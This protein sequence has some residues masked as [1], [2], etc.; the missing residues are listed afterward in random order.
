MII[1]PPFLPSTTGHEMD[2]AD[3]GD[4]VVPAH[5]V[6]EV[7]MQECAPGNGAYP[8][9]FNLGWHGGAHLIAP[10]DSH[11][12]CEPVR[13]IADGTVVYVRETDT[14][15]SV[16]LSYR[17]VRTDDGCVVLKHVTE[18]GFGDHA[19]VAFFS[20]YMHLQSV[21]G[22]LAVGKKVYRKD[23]VGV[24][25]QIYGQQG[26]IH[27]EV[28]CDQRNLEKLVGRTCGQLTAAMGR[29][30]AVY[31]DVW[32]KVP[33]HTLTFANRP[34]PY[35]LDDSGPPPC[36]AIHPQ[37][38]SQTPC[39]L[40]ICMHYEGGQCT[41]TTFEKKDDRYV[42]IGSQPCINDYEYDLYKEA[43]K[44]SA[45]YLALNQAAGCAYA[46][47]PAPST[48]YEFLRFGRVL[49]PDALAANARFGHW[50]QVFVPQS[51]DSAAG[52]RWINL[53]QPTIGVYSDADFPHWAGWS[54]I[55]D[56]TTINT[57]C[58]SPTIRAWLDLN[59]NGHVTHEE[60]VQALHASSVKERLSRAICKIPVEWS[61]VDA[62]IHAR[63]VWLTSASE[64]L[65]NP[66]SL[67]DDFPLLKRHIKALAFWEEVHDAEFPA[68][69][70]CWHFPPKA[71]V[72]HFRKC[73][74]RSLRELTQTLP[75]HSSAGAGNQIAWS[76]ARNR[77]SEGNTNNGFMPP[78]LYVAMNR[79]WAKYG[80]T[81]AR[82]QAHFLAQIFK[83]TGALRATVELGDTRY[84]RTMYEV[85]TPQEAGDDF[86]HKHA[87]LVG[88]N[89]L[90]GR[91]RPTYVAQR[92]GEIHQKAQALGNIQ[93]GDGARFCGRGLIHLTG[94]NSYQS[95][96]LFRNL[97][98][99]TNTS[100]D[101]LSTDA[102]VTADSAG[103][104]WVSKVM[105]SP[106]SGALSSGTNIS[107]RA[108]L[109]EADV[110]VAAITTPVNGGSTGLPERKEFFH[111]VSF[112]LGDAPNM[113]T[114]ST[115][116]RQK[117]D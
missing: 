96:G 111:Y 86:D 110:N 62:V 81:T 36:S 45:Q 3:A 108:D 50:R 114:D 84:F 66:I 25:G 16:E 2:C 80:F 10:R 29:T 51:S 54:L 1:S 91:D 31:G 5:D 33:Q 61:K 77:W 76:L 15:E 100:P 89:F 73:G 104:F 8:V 4:S 115:L 109:G 88:M 64:A 26:Q 53:N 38:A 58:E 82:R 11:G 99:T 13:A 46:T 68:A 21:A 103:Y 9:S 105:Q 97:D 94:R 75:R 35:R 7:G 93:T 72:E 6:C 34:H 49:G 117:E 30:D 20:I 28:V 17:G 55:D 87:W 113:P 83:E 78:R 41:L 48:I 24:P 95:Y 79:M 18:I 98:F 52:A 112:I 92:P 43:N 32:F 70:Q 56:D 101:L 63:W 39:E 60:A 116:T 44:L 47:V 14:T 102:N 71:F 67:Q 74:W 69:D 37:P 23:V 85:L 57:L 65:P 19:S 12:H 22:G 107:R 42:P 90:Q 106:N 59:G 40:V 27:F